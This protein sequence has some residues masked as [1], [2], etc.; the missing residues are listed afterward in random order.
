MYPANFGTLKPPPYA[1]TSKSHQGQD[2]NLSRYLSKLTLWKQKR[3][4]MWKP[5][6]NDMRESNAKLCTIPATSGCNLRMQL[7]YLS[8]SAIAGIDAPSATNNSYLHRSCSWTESKPEKKLVGISLLNQIMIVPCIH[9]DS[10]SECSESMAALDR[11]H[12]NHMGPNYQLH[13][14]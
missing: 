6:D 8:F 3:C 2:D 1:T 14:A 11:W 13:P 12:L 5:I 7:T 9:A 4:I 10:A